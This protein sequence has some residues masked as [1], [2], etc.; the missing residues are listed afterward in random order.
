MQHTMRRTA[1]ERLARAR[2][3]WPD[4]QLAIDQGRVDT[5]LVD[6]HCIATQ[7]VPPYERPEAFMARVLK[8]VSRRV[9][10]PLWQE[11]REAWARSSGA[12]PGPR[13]VMPHCDERV[14]TMIYRRTPGFSHP[15]FPPVTLD[16]ALAHEREIEQYTLEPME[17]DGGHPLVANLVNTVNKATLRGGQAYVPWVREHDPHQRQSLIP[18]L[19]I[20]RSL[21]G[22]VCPY[23]SNRNRS[24]RIRYAAPFGAMHAIFPLGNCIQV[25]LP[26]ISLPLALPL[27]SLLGVSLPGDFP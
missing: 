26:R 7:I 27:S 8:D 9:Y 21:L 13:L 10:Q 17:H 5:S 24:F 16:E 19:A 4:L 3:L 25:R 12:E 14:Q 15:A 11:R 1:S 6:Q 2:D 22:V 23:A 18:I 20:H